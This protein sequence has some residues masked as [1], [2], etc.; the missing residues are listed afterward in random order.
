VEVVVE[1]L[2]LV[3]QVL[4]GEEQEEILEQHQQQVQL[5]QV[6]EEVGQVTHFTQEEQVEK[7]LLY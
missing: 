3:Q 5:I 6:Q 7:E 2:L 4:V 1:V